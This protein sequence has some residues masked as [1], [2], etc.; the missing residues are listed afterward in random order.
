MHA[1][2]EHLET[3]V[4]GDTGKSACEAVPSP[5]SMCA[6][7]VLLHDV[8]SFCFANP[9]ALESVMNTDR[10]KKSEILLGLAD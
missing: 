8:T 5:A 3:L 7:Q 10:S 6:L 9:S 1:V 4:P 2:W